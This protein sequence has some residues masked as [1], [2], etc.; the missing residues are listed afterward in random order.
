MYEWFTERARKV[1]SLSRQ[2]AQR[3]NHENIR[4]EHILLGLAEEG[5]GA[6]ANVLKNMD[7]ELRI[8]RL[9]I[10]KVIEPGSSTLQTS[11]LPLTPRAKKAIELSLEEAN[12]LGHNYIDTEHLLLGLLREEESTAAKVLKKLSLKIEDVREEVL[13]FL[14]AEF[15]Q[16]SSTKSKTPALD[17]FGKDLTV[18]AENLNLAPEYQQETQR[19]F[20]ILLCQNKSPILLDLSRTG[21]NIITSLVQLKNFMVPEQVNDYRIIQLDLAMLVAGTKYRGQLEERIIAITTETV[22]SKNIILFIDDF[23]IL[24]DIRTTYLPVSYAIKLA[25]SSKK[26]K[27]IAATS[28]CEYRRMLRQDN[29]FLGLFQPVN[30][31]SS[32]RNQMQQ[33]LEH[34]RKQYQNYEP[35]MQIHKI[36]KTIRYFL[37]HCISL[38]EALGVFDRIIAKNKLS[39]SSEDSEFLTCES[40]SEIT[41][42]PFHI[43][44]H[45]LGHKSFDNDFDTDK[46]HYQSI[47]RVICQRL[48]GV[49]E[50]L[51]VLGFFVLPL[52]EE[53]CA[54]KSICE[55]LFHH[56]KF[57]SFDAEDF[58]SFCLE[59]L[60]KQLF[61]N[62][63]SL[64][65]IKNINR[66]SPQI[67]DLILQA[68]TTGYW[69]DDF[70]NSI[71]LKN[72]IVV[73]TWEMDAMKNQK[74]LPSVTNKQKVKE[75]FFHA[76]NVQFSSELCQKI[77]DILISDL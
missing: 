38:E 26:I 74:I 64:L 71:S 63:C 20:Q 25:M 65:Y 7:V 23:H 75:H 15:Q 48:T 21:K 60:S 34:K 8:I 54:A 58:S 45:A 42:I 68:A 53:N 49:A 19:V 59:K 56:S 33:I 17:A 24:F 27:L 41:K 46:S 5:S 9:E 14:G 73:A 67:L 57:I 72:I 2:Q 10:E 43:L 30:I 39:N 3:F 22:R 6:A 12:N 1:M 55:H 51:G 52:F 47:L 28:T 77:D 32:N 35:Q 36:E 62:P 37:P 44:R 70:G 69:Q 31:D 18:R 50:P 76:I 66:A 40:L 11:Q 29:T 4:P 61:Y 16:T 13:E